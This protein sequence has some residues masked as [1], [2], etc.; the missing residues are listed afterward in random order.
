MQEQLLALRP[1][2]PTH[3]PVDQTELNGELVRH[4]EEYKLALDTIRIACANAESEL[5]AF[6]A[7]RL[8]RAAEA[9]KALS[10]LLAAPGQV[11]AA[12]E[13]ITVTLQPA[14]TPAE[15]QAFAS[16]LTDLDAWNLTLPADPRPLR[17]RIQ[18]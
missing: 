18:T 15:Q 13:H 14:A 4:T 7:P 10:N 6:L 2:L 12:S 9:K 17:F 11:Q 16:F 1:S 3:A 5:A 8:P